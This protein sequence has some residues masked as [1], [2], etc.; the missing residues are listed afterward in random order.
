MSGVD[1]KAV[2]YSTVIAFR[3]LLP[4]GVVVEWLPTT[5]SPVSNSLPTRLFLLES[6]FFSNE[7]AEACKPQWV[8]FTGT[9]C[10]L[11]CTTGLLIVL[12]IPE[13]AIIHKVEHVDKCSLNAAA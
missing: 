10:C 7:T 11:H 1:G 4:I 9:N 13:P 5:F 12:A 2:M 8:E 3:Q 6:S